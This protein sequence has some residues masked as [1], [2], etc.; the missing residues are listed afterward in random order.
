MMPCPIY[1]VDDE[2]DREYLQQNQAIVEKTPSAGFGFVET[3][4]FT[5]R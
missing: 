4:R 5:S 3:K 1:T 2:P